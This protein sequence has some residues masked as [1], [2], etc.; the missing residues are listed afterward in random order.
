MKNKL[1]SICLLLGIIFRAYFY[2]AGK[3][4]KKEEIVPVISNVIEKERHGNE[5]ILE[6]KN[7]NC[8]VNRLLKENKGWRVEL[9]F[10]GTKEQIKETLNKINK[11]EILTYSLL[12]VEE[13]IKLD[14]QVYCE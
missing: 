14:M 2:F 8:K 13:E 7:L 10:I 3:I 11:Y 12:L 6:F 1:I 9:E 5:Y 4:E